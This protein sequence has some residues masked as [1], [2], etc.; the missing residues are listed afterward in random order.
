MQ[1][2]YY[3]HYSHAGFGIP[4][5]ASNRIAREGQSGIKPCIRTKFREDPISTS[6]IG[7]LFSNIYYWTGLSVLISRSEVEDGH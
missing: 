3:Y 4:D 2:K 7:L 1:K 6:N 5:I